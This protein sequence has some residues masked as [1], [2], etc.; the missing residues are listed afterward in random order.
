MKK[1]VKRVFRKFGLEI[2]RYVS[3]PCEGF[4]SWAP[5]NGC[6][7]NVLLALWIKPFLAQDGEA[8]PNTHAHNW[9]SLQIA[10]TFLDL[11]YR[12]DIID[13][14]NSE[15]MPQKEYAFFVSFRT[16]FGNIVPRLNRECIK[17][18]YLDTAH[19]LFNN[20]ASFKRGL[21]L[22]QR[23]GVTLKGLRIVEA[24]MAIECADYGII[25]GNKFTMDTY[26]YLQK[27]IFH[28]P[29][30]PCGIFP[31]P[32][33]KDFESCRK[34]Y[35]WFGSS[36]FVHKGLDLVL[37]A[38]AE[39]REYNLYVCGPLQEERDFEKAYYKELYETSN[40]HTVGWVDIEGQEFA[41]VTKKCVGLIYPSC[42]EGGGGSVLT[43]MHAGL[44][45]IISYESSVDVED[46][47]IILRESS[48]GEIKDSVQGISSLAPGKL[49][50]MSRKA[51]EYV[52]ASHTRERFAEEFKRT[53][54]HIGEFR[55]RAN[56]N[57]TVRDGS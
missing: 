44:I 22:Q 50:S 56:A 38:F 30:A 26:G 11:G 6:W 51:W 27:A 29:Y 9:R 37:E 16:N 14:L 8:V 32:E 19:W 46:I 2:A 24:N 45:P 49:E 47:G 54:E 1:F 3:N 15:F 31:W 23:R 12:V 5:E 13:Y 28:V 18:V 43:C 17:I 10:K 20:R 57:G 52:R 39:M 40:I 48:I 4:V 25:S 35:L 36:G 7:G 21:D 41:N 34:N 42:S 55:H 33:E 53:V